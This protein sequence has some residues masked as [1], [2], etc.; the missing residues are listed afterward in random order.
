MGIEGETLMFCK[1]ALQLRNLMINNEVVKRNSILLKYTLCMK[2]MIKDEQ[3]WQIINQSDQSR[4]FENI[5]RF[6]LLSDQLNEH[7]CNGLVNFLLTLAS[8]SVYKRIHHII[9][10]FHFVGMYSSGLLD[11]RGINYFKMKIIR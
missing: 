1:Y 2:S 7:V 6:M 9:R 5:S 11:K 10:C 4:F 8:N 3:W